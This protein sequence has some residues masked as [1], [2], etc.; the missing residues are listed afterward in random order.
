MTPVP[1]KEHPDTSANQLVP[2]CA[3]QTVCTAAYVRRRRD[4]ERKAF[5][6]RLGH[7]TQLKWNA[8]GEWIW[9]KESVHE[10]STSR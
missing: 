4:G 1:Q 2:I 6:G 8:P 3:D 5:L 10:L 7:A 9:S